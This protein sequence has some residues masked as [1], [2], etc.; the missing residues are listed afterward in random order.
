MKKKLLFLAFLFFN[1]S[2]FAT[3]IFVDQSAPAGGDGSSWASAFQD[4]QSAIDIAVADDTIFIAAGIYRPE[5]TLEVSVPLNFRGGYPAGGGVQNIDANITQIQADFDTGN[6]LFEVLDIDPDAATSLTGLRFANCRR[7]ISTASNLSI[8]QLQFDQVSGN[9][10]RLQGTFDF[11]LIENS[12]FTNFSDDIISGSSVD[13]QNFDI[14]NT[15]F[16]NSTDRAISLNDDVANFTMTDC[17]I[18][19]FNNNTATISLDT[20][21]ATI[22]NL[23]AED[24]ISSSGSL[25]SLR[26]GTLRLEESVFTNNSGASGAV[27]LQASDSTIEVDNSIFSNNTATATGP[28]SVFLINDCVFT[29]TNSSFT[30]NHADGTF[31]ALADIRADDTDALSTFDNC[32]FYQNSTLGSSQQGIIDASY[33]TTLLI[34]NCVFDANSVPGQY[35]IDSFAGSG[36][37][38]TNN[39]FRNHAVGPG[40]LGIDYVERGLGGGIRIEGNTFINNVNNSIDLGR[41]TDFIARDNRYYGDVGMELDRIPNGQLINEYFEG[42]SNGTRILEVDDINLTI[43]NTVMVS[44][45]ANGTHTLIDAGNDTALE[46]INSTFTATDINDTH[47]RIDFDDDLPSLLRNSIVWSGNANLTQSGFTGTIGNLQVRH[48]L[49]KGEDPAGAGNLDG[50][51]SGNRPRFVS[52]SDSDFRML[53]CSPT[54]NEGNNSYISETSDILKNARVFQTTV[55]M[56]AYELQRNASSSCA[57]PNLPSCANL[58]APGPVDGA[59]NVSINTIIHWDADPNATGY[60]LRVGTALGLRDLVDEV[61][62]NQTSYTLSNLPENAPIFV[63]IVPFNG[64]GNAPSCSSESFTTESIIGLASCAYLT[65][66]ANEDSI[67][68]ANLGQIQWNAV[69]NA[70][71][72]RVTINGSTST[73]NNETNLVVNGTSHAFTNNFTTG[74]T[75]TVSIRPFNAN[76]ITSGCGSETFTIENAAPAVPSS[77]SDLVTPA[78]GATGVAVN[79]ASIAWDAVADATGYRVSVS[80]STSTANNITNQNITGTMH[81]FAN[82]FDNDE[83]VTV[84]IIPFNAQGD[85]VGCA[86]P[87]SFTIESAAPSTDAFITTWKTDNPGLSDDNSIRIPTDGLL[88]Y[89]YTVDWGD[90]TPITTETNAAMHTYAAPGTY[91]VTIRGIF[92]RIVF[93][94]GGDADKLLAIEQWG[95][96]QWSSMKDAFSGCA[97]MVGNFTDRPDLSGVSDMRSMFHDCELFNTNINDWD[98]S[99]VTTMD[100]LFN[101]ALLF[102]QPLNNWD[103]TNVTSMSRMFDAAIAFNQP[104]DLWNVSNVSNMA[105]MF[106]DAIAFNRD[107]GGWVTTNLEFTSSMFRGAIIFNQ[108]IGNWNTSSVVDMSQMFN[109]ASNFDQNIGTWDVS[110]V[111]NMSNMFSGVT[112]STA[113]YDALLIG[114]DAQDL[115]PNVLFSGGNSQYCAGETARMNMITSDTWTITDGGTASPT[116]ND[117]A[118]QNQVNS[119]TLPAITGTQLTGAEAYYTQTNGG[120]TSYDAGDIINFADFPSYPITLYIY[121][122]SGTCASEESFALTLT[123]APTVPS[124][125]ADLVTPANGA[126]GVAINLSSIAWDAVADA[127]GYRVTISGSSSTANNIT[128]Q[129]ITGTT[130]PFANSFDNDETVTVTIIPFNAQGDAVGCATPQTFTIESSVPTVP[131]SCADLVTPA[132]GA[133][134]VAVN[135]ASI[136]WDAVADATAYRVSVSGSTST[137]NN[138]TDQNIT[139]TTHPFANSFDNDETVT[140]TIIPFNAQG[141]AVGCATPQIFT[142]ESSV[143]TVPSSCADLVTPANGATGVAVN[144]ASITWDAVA[145]ATAYRVTISGSTSTANNITDQNITGT[146]HPFANSFDNDE[147]VMVTIIPFNAQGDAVGCATPQTFTIESSVPTVPSSCADLVTPANGAT[148]VEVNTNLSWDAVVDADGY[149]LRVGTSPGGSDILADEDV[150]I[151]T[152]YMLMDELPENSTIYVLITPYNAQGDAVNCTEQSFTTTE[153]IIPEDESLYGFSP[154]GDGINEYWEI[155]GIENHPENTVTIFNRWGD[156]VFQIQNYDNNVN[157]FRGEANRLTKLGAGSLPSGTYFFDI[158]INGEHNL[159]KLR[160]YLVLKR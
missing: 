24:N 48:S 8:N 20:S 3:D 114:W 56:G 160:G 105:R 7:A 117:L 138:I 82:S 50:T 140:V 6:L 57:T 130:H 11:C 19:D 68:P 23:L 110:M 33:D 29:V 112:L 93:D 152:S 79:L 118:D 26:D 14:R 116:V 133:T 39:I 16:Q 94:N 41:M 120:G 125:C 124:S 123:S 102:N 141:D 145:D 60:I 78:S 99:T 113:N 74:E 111:T 34:N 150:G 43:T 54:V 115:Q 159:T 9:A 149:R 119:Y 45:L 100:Q 25:L 12:L 98:V 153:V 70:D 80:G 46:I 135:L 86:T 28:K 84:T 75:V 147:T 143:P 53:T 107:I 10:I 64:Q 22:T 128:D 17:I 131:S 139:G 157:V 18:R 109:N 51:V 49:V 87:Q 5:D 96:I 73:A 158:Q 97:N 71:G 129:N 126:I 122:G 1:Y 101:D 151:L 76:G 156:A 2:L 30:N 44:T 32:Y 104:L 42:N 146:T 31:S 55:D 52:P 136:T 66:P 67:V 47:V 144:L 61:L 142:I 155:V 81:P 65:S 89:N 95:D 72:Y 36:A 69:A 13:L 132:N 40:V 59:T 103:V 63:R 21:N 154:D 90:S 121:D 77:C 4:I 15:I 58:S 91:T 127:T 108:N 137:A 88:T 83:T 35:M 85:A 27:C 106:N 37:T 134:G 62:G 92:P 148:N 38:I